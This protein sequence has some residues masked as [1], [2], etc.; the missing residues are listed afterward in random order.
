MGWVENV[1]D[2]HFPKGG[3]LEASHLYPCRSISFEKRQWLHS[4][5]LP[6]PLVSVLYL[7]MF[8]FLWLWCLEP[9]YSQ[10]SLHSFTNWYYFSS[11]LGHNWG[12]K[13]LSGVCKN[14]ITGKETNGKKVLFKH[15]EITRS[16]SR[17]LY[18]IEQPALASQGQ[19]S[20]GA[21]TS[22][23][24]DPLGHLAAFR[25]H[26]DYCGRFGRAC[27]AAL[28]RSI[29]VLQKGNNNKGNMLLLHALRALIKPHE[30][31][32]QT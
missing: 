13:I 6:I 31:P 5:M 12:K 20:L 29:A 26:S 4:K 28:I 8:S 1:I 15:L 24:A 7:P 25:Q 32:F 30:I 11:P 19:G 23:A 3:K 9:C 14:S 2:F 27:C 18:C 16:L 10:R 17:F 21:R 22:R